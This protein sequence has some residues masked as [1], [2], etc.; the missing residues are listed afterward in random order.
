V[1]LVPALSLPVLMAASLSVDM[2]LLMLLPLACFFGRVVV[3]SELPRFRIPLVP[4]SHFEAASLSNFWTD[5]PEREAIY[6]ITNGGIN[7]PDKI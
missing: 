4:P 1:T 2:F 3:R 7:D 5:C 6:I